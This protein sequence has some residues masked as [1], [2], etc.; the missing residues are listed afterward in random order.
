MLVDSHCHLDASEFDADRGAVMAAARAAGVG[1]FV[2]PGVAVDTFPAVARLAMEQPDVAPAYGIHPLYVPRAGAGDLDALED[3]LQQPGVV[4][5]GE[6]GLDGFVPDLPQAQLSTFFDRQLQLAGRYGLPVIL[7]VRRAVE[8]VIR[9]LRRRPVSG[10]IAHAFNGS[11]QQAE[12][13]MAMGFALGFGGAMSFSGSTR[14]RA[15][16]AGLPLSAL[17][18]ETDAPDMP[19]AWLGGGRNEPANVRRLAETLAELRGVS[20]EEVVSA[21]T[22]NVC[23]VLPGMKNKIARR[24]PPSP[25]GPV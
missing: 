5:V 4:A 22:G 17:V 10:G 6:I 12:T 13:L 20:V 2:V 19:P 15:L 3:W 11:R 9:H 8:E 14:I 7:H 1:W 18:L 16:A 21:T 24:P 23:R 25:P